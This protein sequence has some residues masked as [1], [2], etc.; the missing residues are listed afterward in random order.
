MRITNRYNLPDAIVRAVTNDPY[1]SGDC[2]FSVSQLLQPPQIY[3][4]TKKHWDELE[5][6]VSDRIWSLV[7]QSVH[8]ILER[9]NV[10]AIAERRLVMEL[11]GFK[12]SGGMDSFHPESGTLTDYKV[13]NV[14]KVMKSDYEDW[15]L[16]LNFYRAILM[17]NGERV[18]NLK[19]V[20]ILRDW[21]KR[22]V[23]KKAGYP[24][25][26]VVTVPIQVMDHAKVLELMLQKANALREAETR[27][28]GGVAARNCSP[29]ER[30]ANP[31]S[32]GKRCEDYCSISRAGKCDQYNKY[33]R[34]GDV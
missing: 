17:A 32:Y 30:W 3:A 11:G 9:A 20:A 18:D 15:I 26:Q 33:L 13:T 25:C 6:D 14:F 31:K 27:V 8:T 22:E 4:L 19:I 29:N 7:G 34:N 5:E 24:E 28:M 2:D 10:E 21:M 16:Q 23:G 1:N 12:I